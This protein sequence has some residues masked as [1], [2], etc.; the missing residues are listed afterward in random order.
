MA[1][2]HKPQVSVSDESL[3]PWMKRLVA[4]IRHR[5]ELHLTLAAIVVLQLLIYQ[6][7]E[8]T[9]IRFHCEEYALSIDYNYRT[10]RD[11]I[12]RLREIDC[13]RMTTFKGSQYV[14]VDP[15]LANRGNPKYRALKIKLWQEAIPYKRIRDIN[16]LI[17]DDKY[18][19]QDGHS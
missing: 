6:S 8:R 19:I 18:Y 4:I 5:E 15:L 17:C 12:Q 10:L 1:K 3:P 13:I 9:L 16:Q 14:I 7:W 11:V 2:H